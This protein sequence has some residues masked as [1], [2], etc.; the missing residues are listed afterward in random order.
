MGRPMTRA[1]LDTHVVLWWFSD[2]D[3][4]SPRARRVIGD[5]STEVYVS[6]ATAW[7]IATKQRIG[8]LSGLPTASE[9]LLELIAENGFLHL[10][11]TLRHGIHAGAYRVDHRDPFDRMLAAQSELEEL[12]L[13]TRDSAF[14]YF[15]VTTLW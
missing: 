1:L 11:V 6:A 8:K 7:E 14:K 10:P 12:V 2:D 15:D 13:V 3:R 5:A 9:R 4:L